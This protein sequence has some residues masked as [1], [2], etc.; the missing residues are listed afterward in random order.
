[1]TIRVTT[2]VGIPAGLV[3]VLLMA[4]LACGCG[5]DEPEFCWAGVD[6]LYVSG[7][8]VSDTASVRQAFEAYVAFVDT[9]AAEF[10]RDEDWEYLNSR[11]FDEWRG[12]FYWQ[13]EHEAYA[14]DLELRLSRRIAYVDENGVVVLALGCI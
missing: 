8:S 2:G 13:V 6:T 11:P 14:P 5:E 7:I 10:P 3:G 9:T 4:L 1:M 12:R